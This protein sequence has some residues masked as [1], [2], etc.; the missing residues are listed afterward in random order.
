[1]EEGAIKEELE[2]GASRNWKMGQ[3][4]IGKWNK[5]EILR[6]IGR[7]TKL[8]KKGLEKGLWM[9]QVRGP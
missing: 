6:K 7:K 8:Q 9:E 5:Q 1:M 2:E 4:G 3:A